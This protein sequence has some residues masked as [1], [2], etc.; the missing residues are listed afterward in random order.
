MQRHCQQ[1]LTV[2]GNY[3][4][5]A[6]NSQVFPN[7]LR[8]KSVTRSYPVKAISQPVRGYAGKLIIQGF[9]QYAT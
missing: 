1:V 8:S 3:F 4:Q 2:Y 9:K 7:S 6:L 5:Y